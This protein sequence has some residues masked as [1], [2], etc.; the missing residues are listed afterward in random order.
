MRLLFDAS[1]LLNVIR[2]HKQD[3]YRL[4]KGNLTLSLTKYEVGNALWK[5]A[6]LLKRV[7]INE[8]LETISLLDKVLK[9]MET[10]NPSNPSLTLNLAYKLQT[11]Y[12]DASYIAASTEKNAKLI[13]DDT[14]LTRKVEEYMNTIHKILG[15]KPEISSSNKI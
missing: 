10:V 1:A 15:R 14:K 8:A 5:E 4:L 2:L 9:T 7:S 12:Y 11:T 6:L 3:A 13:T